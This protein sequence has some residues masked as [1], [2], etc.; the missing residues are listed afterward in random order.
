M[1]Y[2][3]YHPAAALSDYVDSICYIEGNNKGTGL[4]KV[5]MSLVFNLEDSF[6]LFADE[7]FSCFTDYKRYWLAGL[8]TRPA[9]VE[10][11][12]SS[13]ML[14]V[15]FRSL[16]AFMF[17]NDPLHHYTNQYVS[18]DDVLGCEVEQTW[19]QLHL[20]GSVGQQ[21]AVVERFLLGRLRG[22]KVPHKLLSGVDLLLREG[23]SCSIGEVCRRLNIS[24]KHLN[25]LSLQFSGVSPKTLSSLHR[26]QRTLKAVSSAPSHKLTDRAY[27]FG[28]CDQA[29]FIHD[30]RRFTAMTPATYAGLVKMN[31][32]MSIVPHFIPFF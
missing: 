19:E 22:S 29:H 9:R 20:A 23:S 21:F 4:P 16:G 27:E 6:K 5:A 32:S 12:G 7:S 14:V 17:L 11:Y 24:R 18:L 15:Q 13:R 2:K 3:T 10:S 30:F 28:Y 8:Q 31:P 26:L 25:H 1:I